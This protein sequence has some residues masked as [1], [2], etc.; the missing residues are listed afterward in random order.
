M[1]E[2]RK[3]QEAALV[4]SFCLP[5]LSRVR[6]VTTLDRKL[7]GHKSEPRQKFATVTHL[8]PFSAFQPFFLLS[9]KKDLQLGLCYLHLS[10]NILFN[11]MCCQ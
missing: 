2:G 5:R 8:L 6:T 11:P 3:R 4:V 10:K 9:S 7:P 1:L